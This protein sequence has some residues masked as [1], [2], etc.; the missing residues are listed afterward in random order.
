LFV[1]KAALAEETVDTLLAAVPVG[2]TFEVRKGKV[3]DGKGNEV[4][5]EIPYLKLPG[6]GSQAMSFTDAKEKIP[7]LK[8]LRSAD[9][10][11]PGGT[12]QIEFV[13]QGTDGATTNV[14]DRIREEAK[15]RDE[16]AKAI[17]AVTPAED[18]LARLR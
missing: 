9:P 18:R 1:R 10:K 15:Q 6:E 2:T 13:Q 16:A 5:G 17:P 12:Q 8:G 4:D 7:A 14:F 11:A 3:K